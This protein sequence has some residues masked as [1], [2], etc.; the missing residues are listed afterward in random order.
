M[1]APRNEK[2]VLHLE[3]G[4]IVSHTTAQSRLDCSDIHTAQET[5][6][7]LHHSLL[8]IPLDGKK[9]SECISKTRNVS[10]TCP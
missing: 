3:S 5:Y 10:Y 9:R 2:K 8:C 6:M 7:T 4:F 1:L